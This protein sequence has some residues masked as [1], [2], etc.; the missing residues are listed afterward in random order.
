[1][2]INELSNQTVKS[3]CGPIIEP[4]VKLRSVAIVNCQDTLFIAAPHIP[5]LKKITIV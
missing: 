2:E 3:N 1:M 5:V 4:A